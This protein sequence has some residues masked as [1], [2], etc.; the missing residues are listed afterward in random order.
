[1]LDYRS[2]GHGPPDR[3]TV[4]TRSE[5]ACG[6]YRVR[7]GLGRTDGAARTVCQSRRKSL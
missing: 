6:T 7:A 2:T 1:L 5:P 4:R 3:R